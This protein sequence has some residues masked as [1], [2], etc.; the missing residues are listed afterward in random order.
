MGHHR[1]ELPGREMGRGTYHRRWD[2]QDGNWQIGR[3]EEE[4]PQE[5]GHPRWELADREM[6]RGITTGDGTSKMR[7]WDI[8]DGNWQAELG[9]LPARETGRGIY[10]RQVGRWEEEFTT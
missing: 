7:R 2:I 1:P 3:W 5:M 4:L 8:Q 10:R 6:G 9:E